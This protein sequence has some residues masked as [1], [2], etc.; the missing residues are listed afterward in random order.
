MGLTTWSPLASGLLTVKYGN[1]IP[2]DSRGAL[3]GMGFLVNGL[4]DAA[5]NAALVHLDAEAS[6]L[7]CSL[8]QLAI[9]WVAKNPRV[10]TVIT[11][12]SKLA[13]LQEN[14]GALEVMPKL[15]PEVMARIDE[16]TLSLAA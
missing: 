14:L 4:T 5:K 13:Q 2:K 7:G 15:T 16:V 1:G 12:A 9:A 6:D 11:G 8:S 3:E 10:S